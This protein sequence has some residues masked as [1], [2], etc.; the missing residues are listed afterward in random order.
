MPIEGSQG[1]VGW[2]G[3]TRGE[4]RVAFSLGEAAGDGSF[5]FLEHEREHEHGHGHGHEHEPMKGEKRLK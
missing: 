5:A 4:Q 1:G 3:I 2:M